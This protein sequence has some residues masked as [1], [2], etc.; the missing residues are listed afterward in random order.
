M[1]KHQLDAQLTIL[2][3]TFWRTSC[4]RS[5]A[6]PAYHSHI[7]SY[8]LC[9]VN[10]QACVL[11]CFLWYCMNDLFPMPDMN[12]LPHML[13]P[14]GTWMLCPAV[15]MALGLA[16]ASPRSTC[17]A[18]CVTAALRFLLPVLLIKAIFSP[19]RSL[20]LPEVVGASAS[21]SSMLLAVGIRNALLLR[22]LSGVLPPVLLMQP[23]SNPQGRWAWQEMLCNACLLITGLN[24]RTGEGQRSKGDRGPRGSR[25]TA[26]ELRRRNVTVKVLLP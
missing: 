2:S 22:V 9:V 24:S 3:Q 17:G 11:L 15:P 8:Q 26:D 21:G 10:H 7:V 1:H 12:S 4:A 23:T 16:R 5:G 6:L 20:P 14:C 18:A 25:R 19:S 13:G